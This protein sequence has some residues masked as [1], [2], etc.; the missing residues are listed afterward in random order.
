LKFNPNN[1]LSKIT[2]DDKNHKYEVGS[3]QSSEMA[4]AESKR[5]RNGELDMTGDNS[6]GIVLY[7]IIVVYA[8]LILAFYLAKKG[9]VEYI[10]ENMAEQVQTKEWRNNRLLLQ[11]NLKKWIFDYRPGEL[12][13]G[14]NLEDW[15]RMAII[16]RKTNYVSTDLLSNISFNCTNKILCSP[17]SNLATELS[18]NMYG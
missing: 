6:R 14:T 7:I 13:N 9:E 4:G 16:K 2:M 3:D 12:I 8:V 15:I 18:L 11:V 10:K 1:N 17:E 5:K